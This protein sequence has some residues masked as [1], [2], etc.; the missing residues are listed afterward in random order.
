MFGRATI[1]LGIGPHSS[2]IICVIDAEGLLKF[3]GIQV[4]CKKVISLKRQN[5]DVVTT[6]YRPLIGSDM[7]PID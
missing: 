6:E 5:S 1:T 3:T 7:W 2:C 4:R